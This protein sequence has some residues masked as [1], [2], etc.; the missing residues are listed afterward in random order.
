MFHESWKKF[1]FAFLGAN[2]FTEI[3]NGKRR[4]GSTASK[5]TV[6]YVSGGLT[7]NAAAAYTDAKTKG[8]ICIGRL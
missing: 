2:S 4:A 1:Q 3:H 5:P 7:I 8:N 6:S